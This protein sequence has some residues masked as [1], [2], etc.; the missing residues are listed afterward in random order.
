VREALPGQDGGTV[1]DEASGS[2]STV[3]TLRGVGAYQITANVF[4][5][6]LRESAIKVGV[7]LCASQR[8]RADLRQA[9]DALAENT[10]LSAGDL[11]HCAGSVLPSVVERRCTAGINCVAA[12]AMGS[13]LNAM[14]ASGAEAKLCER[15]LVGLCTGLLEALVVETAAPLAADELDRREAFS[16]VRRRRRPPAWLG[17]WRQGADALARRRRLSA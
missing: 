10:R 9:I 15:T 12:E 1:A 2:A 16:E 7:F 11:E 6:Q 4:A 5:F 14:V 3:A 8:G 17:R 13:V